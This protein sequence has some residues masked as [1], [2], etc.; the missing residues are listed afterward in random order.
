ML[1]GAERAV[2]SLLVIQ[3]AEGSVEPPMGQVLEMQRIRYLPCT[4]TAGN[5]KEAEDMEINTC[6]SLK[7][8]AVR[9]NLLE[10]IGPCALKT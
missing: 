9:W 6:S 8:S 4:P 2:V 1:Q 7:K 5:L 3:A 10:L